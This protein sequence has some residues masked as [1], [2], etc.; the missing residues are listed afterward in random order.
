MAADDGLDLVALG[1]GPG[2]GAALGAVLGF[3]EPAVRRA[4]SLLRRLGFD[5]SHG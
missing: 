5:L 3:D 4:L 2:L 1:A